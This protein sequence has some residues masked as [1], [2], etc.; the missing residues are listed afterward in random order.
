MLR[1]ADVLRLSALALLAI[2]VLAVHSA[3]MNLYA[4]P[5]ESGVAARWLGMFA[6]KH[7]A[8]AVLAAVAML[9]ASQFD[10][11]SWLRRR[12]WT[13]PVLYALPLAVGLCVLVLVPGIGVEVNGAK[14]WLA[15]PGA[16]LSFQPSEVMKW[17]LLAALAAWC[18]KR[19][20]RMGSFV[21]GLLPAG[22]LVA[23]GCGLILKEDLGT[24]VLLGGVCLVVLVAGGARLLQLS[25]FV[26]AGL[27]AAAAGIMTSDYR[28]RRLTAF[29]DPWADPAGSGY[30]PIQSMLSFAQGGLTGSG[31]GQSVQK[32]HVP[33]ETTDFILPVLSEELGFAGVAAVVALYLLL[34]WAG[35]AAAGKQKDAVGRILCLGVVLMI[36]TQA[37]INLAVVTVVVPTKGIALPLVS[38]GGTGWVLTA[39]AIGAVAGMARSAE[40]DDHDPASDSTPDA[41]SSCHPVAAGIP[42][43]AS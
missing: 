29:L 32:Y 22:L 12:G 38:A 1:C 33:E 6:S 14:R 30:H 41:P 37:A 8:L 4:Q 15:I 21:Q 5:S 9:L 2:G 23:V 7:T 16:G 34:L 42:F 39:A 26:V 17:T 18:G 36:A 35:V 27:A 11:A 43:R 31:L 20:D 10:A 19:S 24:A 13:N 25:P 3:G 28:V 40:Q